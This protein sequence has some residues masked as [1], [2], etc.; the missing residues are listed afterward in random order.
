[1]CSF[2]G[3]FGSFSLGDNKGRGKN[4]NER[5]AL[6]NNEDVLPRGGSSGAVLELSKNLE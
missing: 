1:M 3:Q 6:A 2:D 4:R 5:L